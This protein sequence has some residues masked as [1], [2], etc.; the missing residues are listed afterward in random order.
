MPLDQT[1][2]GVLGIYVDCVRV[3]ACVC[4]C[5]C[6]SAHLNQGHERGVSQGEHGEGVK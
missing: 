3:C 6:A 2:S 4:A 5:V 1:C